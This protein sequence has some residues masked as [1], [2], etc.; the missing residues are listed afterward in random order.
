MACWSRRGQWLP[1]LGTDRR[2]GVVGRTG[3]CVVPADAAAAA[4]GSGDPVHGGRDGV[5]RPLLVALAGRSAR[6]GNVGALA[7]P[8]ARV[9]GSRA[10]RGAAG[11]STTVAAPPPPRPRPPPLG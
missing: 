3:L 9:R 5:D 6:R 1:G 8:D 7:V 11:T 2:Y 4:D 10:G